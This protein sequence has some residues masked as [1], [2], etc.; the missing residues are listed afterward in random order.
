MQ[1]APEHLADLKNSGLTAE[2]IEEA[3]IY[4]V[5]PSD[6][7]KVIGWNMPIKSLLAFP[8]PKCDHFTRYK[9]FPHFTPKDG[10][11]MR[12]FQPKGSS[13]HLYFPPGFDHS[14]D[15]IRITEGEKKALKGTQDG[16]NVLG[17]GG[18]WNFAVKNAEGM[19]H[20]IEEFSLVEWEGKKVELI[21]DSDFFQN[22]CIKRAVFRLGKLL[23][24]QGAIVNI[25]CFYYPNAKKIG[26][27]DF[28]VKNGSRAFFDLP[29]TRR[30]NLSYNVFNKVRKTE[31]KTEQ[32]DST[33]KES[34][35]KK[36]VNLIDNLNVQLFHDEKK[37]PYAV[38]SNGS[39]RMIC[40]VRGRE[41]RAWC[42]RQFWRTESQAPSADAF[43]SALNVIEGMALYDDGKQHVLN[44]RVAWQEN[45][46]WYDLTNEK[47]QA[48][49]ITNEGWCIIDEPPILF[50]RYSHQVPQT[51]P[52]T[53][54]N[55]DLI[56]DFV[57]IK[58]DQHRLLYKVY[59][60]SSF[61]PDI[62]HP[63]LVPHGEQGTAK[64]T[65][66]KISK[67][68]ID[69]SV[70][71][72]LQLPRDNTD[73][74]QQL[75]HHWVACFDNVSSLSVEYSDLICRAVTGQ[76]F[77]KRALYTDDDDVIYAFKRI[78]ALNGINI[79]VTQSDLMDRSIL[80]ELHPIPDGARME[81]KQMWA[82][83]LMVKPLIL[84]GIFDV[85]SRSI[86]LYPESNLPRLF[87]M[88]DFTRWGCAITMALGCDPAAFIRAYEANIKTQNDEVLGSNAVT[89]ALYSFMKDRNGW[90]GSAAELL[91]ELEFIAEDLHINVKDKSWPKA[92]NVL[93]RKLNILKPN[94]RRIG[95]VVENYKDDVKRSLRLFRKNSPDD[96][97]DGSD[98][99]KKHTVRKM[100]SNINSSDGTDGTDGISHLY[101]SGNCLD[102]PIDE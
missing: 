27:D 15:N 55:L 36:L 86:K 48:I 95:I 60:I 12:Y 30:F 92:G 16:L 43:N 50:R 25:A 70:L 7:N 54:G 75:D 29:V 93:T 8:Y 100:C 34:Q 10:R 89:H 1:L 96:T 102:I 77:S 18:I 23:E 76:G 53:G 94:L 52:Q 41:F 68:I 32:L 101:G 42:A 13:P 67:Q 45:A 64:T 80:I 99:Q 91:N 47:W 97:P 9:L 2:T 5:P 59:L 4:S 31:N 33:T 26:L 71:D 78:V 46:I 82:E 49:K 62:A 58:D 20:L 24:A 40:C 39:T 35:S 87:R 38:L 69:P 66:C 11:S 73:F 6:I 79:A 83:F 65:L 85:L 74:V 88:A 37:S 51:K 44:N 19:P 81:E 72:V 61:I 57:N 21:P 98:G 3:G 56:W 84:G 63:V 22:E 14:A 28:L 90:Q 17:L